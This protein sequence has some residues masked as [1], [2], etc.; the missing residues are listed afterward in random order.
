MPFKTK[1]MKYHSI[2]FASILLVIV[3]CNRKGCKDHTAINYDD[4]AKINRYCHYDGGAY[5]YW[6]N[7]TDHNLYSDS[8]KMLHFYIDGELIGSSST[9]KY[10]LESASCS[11]NSNQPVA[12]SVIKDLGTA[13]IKSFTY[14][15]INDLDSLMFS[16]FVDFAGNSCER[17]ELVY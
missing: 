15:V 17:I 10:V 6:N 2:L 7:N 8:C 9:Q 13:K 1:C 4:R 12:I 16:G 14:E 3:A 11:P 5:F